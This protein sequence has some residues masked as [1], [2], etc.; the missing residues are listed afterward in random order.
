MTIQGFPFA[1]VVIAHDATP[2]DGA[3]VAELARLAADA[4][5][6]PVIVAV[7]PGIEV[8]DA[9][10]VVRTRASGLA[11]AAIR[12]GMAQLTN[13]IARAALLV[14]HWAE[15]RSLVA[16]LALV[17]AGKRS[18]EAIVAFEGAALDRSPLLVPR[19]AWLE[20]VT[21]G[22]TGSRRWRLGAG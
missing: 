7:P 1:A 15:R 17:D 3:L 11:I 8:S 4:G 5:A 14:P 12:L 9:T 2:M 22:E 19:D 6:T 21:L 18:P 20:L 13:T 16:L 10:R